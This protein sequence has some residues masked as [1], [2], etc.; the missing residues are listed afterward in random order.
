MLSDHSDGKVMVRRCQ[1]QHESGRCSTQ[2]RRTLDTRCLRAALAKVRGRDL[3]WGCIV[4]LLREFFFREL[5]FYCSVAR[6]QWR[7]G[8]SLP[9]DGDCARVVREAE[10]HGGMAR[11]GP[12]V[13][14]GDVA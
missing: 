13:T 10:A 6:L 9:N 4:V 12:C 1:V 8:V 11:I 3:D 14:S 5:L 7:D 2:G